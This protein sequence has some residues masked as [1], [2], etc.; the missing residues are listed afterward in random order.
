MSEQH[1]STGSAQRVATPFQIEGVRVERV[2]TSGSFER[3]STSPVTATKTMP[4]MARRTRF[5]KGG[6]D[7]GRSR[8]R[9]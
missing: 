2:V 6:S 4:M 1:K 9:P 5:T 7:S 8:F 3:E